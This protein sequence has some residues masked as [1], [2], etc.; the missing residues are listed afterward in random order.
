MVRIGF[1]N[2]AMA[3]V[4]LRGGGAVEGATAAPPVAAAARTTLVG[5]LCV[6]VLSMAV[7]VRLMDANDGEPRRRRPTSFAEAILLSL[8]LASCAVA[9]G[10]LGATGW[11]G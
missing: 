6:G 2:C 7:G 11:L 5:S 8:S 9:A 4:V 1:V 3:A 10:F